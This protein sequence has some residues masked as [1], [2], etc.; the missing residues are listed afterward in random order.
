MHIELIDNIKQFDKLKDEWD[1][2]Y[3][4]D[5]NATVFVSWAWLRGWIEITSDD[6]FVLAIRPDKS[7]SY[8]AFLA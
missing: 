6:W 1:A 5:P 3:L 2:V 7:M 4:A 8:V